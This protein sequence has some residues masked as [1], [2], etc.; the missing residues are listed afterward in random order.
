MADLVKDAGFIRSK[1]GNSWAY[2][3]TDV[4]G[5]ITGGDA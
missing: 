4:T 3:R 1:G 2:V 5:S